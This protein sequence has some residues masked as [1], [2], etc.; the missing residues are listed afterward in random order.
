MNAAIVTSN[1]ETT[2]D[3]IFLPAYLEEWKVNKNVWVN[4][5]YTYEEKD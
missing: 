4:P 5:A 1:F 2:F 3:A